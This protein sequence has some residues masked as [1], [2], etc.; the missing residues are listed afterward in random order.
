ME[1]TESYTITASRSIPVTVS[2]KC[3]YCGHMNNSLPAKIRVEE[4]VKGYRGNKKKEM[5]A[6]RKADLKMQTIRSQAASGAYRGD[7][8]VVRCEKCHRQEPWSRINSRVPLIVLIV[9]VIVAA[10][11]LV[12]VTLKSK[13][14]TAKFLFA[15]SALLSVVV[16]L[17]YIRTRKARCKEQI[18]KL[19][20][21]SL[22]RVRFR[23]RKK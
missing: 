18:E 23:N 16:F 20:V 5:E 3:S 13:G 17:L 21:D 11:A 22:P 9:S 2:Y 6:E 14:Y 19:P 1:Y 15:F 4:T 8:L 12:I 10:V 7:G